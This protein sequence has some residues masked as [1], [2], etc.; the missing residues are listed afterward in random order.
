MPTAK[1]AASG[2]LDAIST[3]LGLSKGSVEESAIISIERLRDP[4]RVCTLRVFNATGAALE[5]KKTP[6][7]ESKSNSALTVTFINASCWYGLHLLVSS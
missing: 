2:L 5:S 1:L 6:Y 4:F 3:W 7:G